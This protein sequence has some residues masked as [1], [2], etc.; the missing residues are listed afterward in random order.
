MPTFVGRFVRI[1]RLPEPLGATTA[2]RFSGSAPG[3]HSARE[4]LCAL[5]PTIPRLKGPAIDRRWDDPNDG[6]AKV[7]LSD[8]WLQFDLEINRWRSR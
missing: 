3:V 7:T 2:P 1:G 5:L 8:V 4:R 6:S